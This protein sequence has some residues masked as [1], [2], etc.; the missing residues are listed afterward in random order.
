MHVDVQCNEMYIT[1]F[2][3]PEYS[4]TTDKQTTVQLET[5]VNTVNTIASEVKEAELTTM[6][7]KHEVKISQNV[8]K[9][10]KENIKITV[11]QS[12]LVFNEC[13]GLNPV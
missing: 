4:Y 1:K 11:E 2:F 5:D 12:L 7:Y 10:V 13:A 3:I 9:D 8:D 6:Q